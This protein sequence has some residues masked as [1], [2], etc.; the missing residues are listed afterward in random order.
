MKKMLDINEPNIAPYDAGHQPRLP[1]T[2]PPNK[3]IM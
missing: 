2:E 3:A 1:C